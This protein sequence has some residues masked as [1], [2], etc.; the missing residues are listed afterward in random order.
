MTA[1]LDALDRGVIEAGGM[2]ADAMARLGLFT[3]ALATYQSAYHMDR[4]PS[5][6]KGLS[7]KIATVK[8]TLSNQRDNASRQ[9]LLHE[10][11]EQDRVVRPK[12]IA[13][14]PPASIGGSRKEVA[15]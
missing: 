1:D 3:E 4:S 10:A 2:A 13:K 7:A 14:S 6:R 15:P 9:P 8:S 12:L 11:L 5:V